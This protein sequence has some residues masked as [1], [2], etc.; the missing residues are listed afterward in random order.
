MRYYYNGCFGAEIG[1]G[2]S[3]VKFSVG[4]QRCCRLIK[5]QQAVTEILEDILLQ[6]DN[7]ALHQAVEIIQ[8]LVVE[9]QLAPELAVVQATQEPEDQAVLVQQIQLQVNRL[10]EP[11]AE[12]DV[13]G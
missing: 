6:K 13:V 11:A 3:D 5:D 9:A 1:Q 8:L 10:Q 7:P 2:F 4:I 12:A